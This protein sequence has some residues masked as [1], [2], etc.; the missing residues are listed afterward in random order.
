MAITSEQLSELNDLLTA[1]SGEEGKLS[2]WERGFVSDQLNR[3]EKYGQNIYMSPKQWAALR[4]IHKSVVGDPFE[5][6]EAPDMD[7]EVPF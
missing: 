2:E 6:D 3:V 5:R 1:I 4:R 7:D